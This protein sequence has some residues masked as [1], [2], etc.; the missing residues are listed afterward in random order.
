MKLNDKV[1]I[2]EGMNAGKV[3]TLVDMYM[4]AFDPKINL[5]V[6][7]EGDPKVHVYYREDLE[8]A[9]VAIRCWCGQATDTDEDGELY[10][11]FM[12]GAHVPVP[13][14]V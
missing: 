2:T 3:G 13:V 12:P 10:C 14:T 4:T 8:I 1:R 6:K 5:H 7:F 9:E 11:T